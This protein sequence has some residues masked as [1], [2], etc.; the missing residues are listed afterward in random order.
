MTPAERGRA[1]T[2]LAPCSVGDLLDRITILRIKHA[3]CSDGQRANVARELAQLEVLAGDEPEMEELSAVNLALW[4]VE[5]RLRAAEAEAR[6]GEAF[7]ADARS[8]Y[9]LNDRRAAIKKALNARLGSDI[10]EEKVHPEY[11]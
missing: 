7:V 6:F 11:R 10:V 2:V 8:V 3:R 4:E 1:A 9:R 5:D